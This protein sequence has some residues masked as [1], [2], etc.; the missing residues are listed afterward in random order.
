MKDLLLVVTFYFLCISESISQFNHVFNGDFEIYSGCPTNTVQ[1][2]SCVGWRSFTSSSPD[3]FNACNVWPVGVPSNLF[4]YKYAASGN[5]YMGLY[6]TPFSSSTPPY[7]EYTTSK[8]EPLQIGLQYE[9][10]LSASDSWKYG[11]TDNIGIYFFKDA[12]SYYG[13]TA[14]TPPVVPQVDWIGAIV[15]YDTLNWVRLTAVF[16]ADSAY[17]NI[18]IG[19]FRKDAA[20]QSV[21][22]PSGYVYFDSVVITVH[23]S[24]IYSFPDT[25][26]C[27]G[28]TV[29][30]Q[31]HV[32]Q[33]K[34]ANNVF[35][36][37]LSDAAGGFTNPINIG[38]VSSDSS[39]TLKG[40]I[41]INAVS[42]Q[43][44]RL[45]II[46]SGFPD[47][48]YASKTLNITQLFP[49][50]IT[51]SASTCAGDTLK[52]NASNS[53]TVANYQW[54]GP[55]NFFSVQQDTFIANSGAAN[56]GWYKIIHSINGCFSTDSILVA[57]NPVPPAPQAGYSEPL[58]VSETLLLN[59]ANVAGATYTWKGPT[60]YNTNIQ[61]ATR[62]NMRFADT[63]IYNVSVS[64][65]GC[66]SPETPIE[67][68]LNPQ[69]FVTIYP[70][71]GNSICINEQA[72]FTALPNLY[73]GNP[74]YTWYIN[75]Q[76]VSTGISF[77]TNS[78]TDQ[79]VIRCEMTEYTK[80]NLPFTD[81]SNDIIMTVLNYK[82]PSVKIATDINPPWNNNTI[83][84]FTAIAMNASSTTGTPPAYQ[85]KKNG[86]D[87]GGAVND[88]WAVNTHALAANDKV[89]V[90]ITSN[91]ECPMPDTVLSNCIN[92]D[93]T[94]VND[95]YGVSVKIHPN[96]V[97]DVLYIT[98][99][100]AFV[101]AALFDHLGRKVEADY[102][103]NSIAVQALPKGY[104]ILRLTDRYGGRLYFKVNKE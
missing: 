91:Y 66:T 82:V 52:L 5:G 4:G 88:Y 44:Y 36:L 72:I 97:S 23:D 71:P 33:R 39:G 68:R 58:C 86:R 101:D 50:S 93:F 54:A 49:P 61:Y 104:Y 18:V 57:V 79:D 85:W 19:G 34:L 30:V 63:G 77:S 81:L 87:I 29:T 21:G 6:N 25:A 55:A 46:A 92:A 59:A 89:C 35:T 12:P 40:I 96:P 3:Y 10:S 95:I 60:G 78:L 69:P 90:N 51:S 80:C 100:F 56:A 9:V 98:S 17:D 22:I 94:N 45:R 26:Y 38:S 28:D 83:V 102:R 42:G 31:Y 53:T 43:Q 74:N 20:V 48:S 11:G 27:S 99:P 84:T 13:S 62:N 8:I 2:D 41:P 73:S 64:V 65:N 67:V 32:E 70:Q 47:T 75:N 37:Q 103:N 7:R 76:P 16:T 15:V 1:T 24:F 14:T